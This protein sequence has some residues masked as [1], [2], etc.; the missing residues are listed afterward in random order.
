MTIAA[1]LRARRLFGA[2][3]DEEELVVI[4]VERS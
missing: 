3:E 1:A 4:R 2:D